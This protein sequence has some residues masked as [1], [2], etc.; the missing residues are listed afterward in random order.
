MYKL[1]VYMPLAYQKQYLPHHLLRVSKQ[2][3]FDLTALR[4]VQ[5]VLAS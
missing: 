3:G 1:Y 4:E 5:N 2:D